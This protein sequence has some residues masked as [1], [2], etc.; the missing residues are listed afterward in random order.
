MAVEAVHVRGDPA[1]DYAR[2][3]R[4]TSAQAPVPS[5][6]TSQHAP[7]IGRHHPDKSSMFLTCWPLLTLGQSR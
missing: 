3:P 7:S 4:G 5:L 2:A 6:V 1:R